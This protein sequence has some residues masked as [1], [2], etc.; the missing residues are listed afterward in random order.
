MSKRLDLKHADVDSLLAEYADA[1]LMH[2]R[3]SREGKHKIA[4]PAY[5]RLSAIV[6]ELLRRGPGA[7]GAL[8]SLLADPRTEVRGWAATHALGFAPEHASLV[9]EEIASGP[10][11]L[12]EFSAKMV[13]QQWRAGALRP[14]LGSANEGS[15]KSDDVEQ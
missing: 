14:P 10:S 7:Q 2:R 12:E 6:R 4:N 9:L 8:L 1:A 5:K 11:S 3:A 13:L 15:P